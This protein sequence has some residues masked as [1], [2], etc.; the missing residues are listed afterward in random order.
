MVVNLRILFYFNPRSPC[1][2]RQ[3]KHGRDFLYPP[4]Q[5]TLPVWGATLLRAWLPFWKFYFNP[6]SPCGERHQLKR[7]D[8]Y[9]F[10]SIHAP[11][12]GSDTSSSAARSGGRDFNPRSPC[13]ERLRQLG[14]L[15]S[16]ILFQSTLPVWG[17]TKLLPGLNKLLGF[18]STLPVWGAT[19]KLFLKGVFNLYFNPRSPC[20]ERRPRASFNQLKRDISIHAPRVGSDPAALVSC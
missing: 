9:I 7:D 14:S 2:E 16:W 15:N 1:G 11:R 8:P 12:V 4:F 13:G 18:Q 10:I 6:R 19:V 17:A 20:G 3:P 5:S